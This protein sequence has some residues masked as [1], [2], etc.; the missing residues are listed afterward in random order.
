M[1]AGTA[2]MSWKFSSSA[3]LNSS[4]LSW[5]SEGKFTS[6]VND[7]CLKKLFSDHSKC[8]VNVSVPCLISL[9]AND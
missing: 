7:T 9:S 8:N 2:E 3:S 5:K 4:H 1:A 6:Q